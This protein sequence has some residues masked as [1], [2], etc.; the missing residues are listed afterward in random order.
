MKPCFLIYK[1]GIEASSVGVKRGGNANEI[2]QAPAQR[3]A[4]QEFLRKLTWILWQWLLVGS[5]EKVQSQSLGWTGR[6]T[7]LG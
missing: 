3:S 1:L 5:A 2:M 4:L 6:S 7:E